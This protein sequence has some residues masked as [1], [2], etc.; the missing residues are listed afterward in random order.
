MKSYHTIYCV[1]SAYSRT[2]NP[3]FSVIKDVAMINF[4]HRLLG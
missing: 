4:F 1:N 2:V 3:P